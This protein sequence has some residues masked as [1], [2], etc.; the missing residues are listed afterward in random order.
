LEFLQSANSV[1]ADTATNLPFPSLPS[2]PLPRTPS[3]VTYH[4]VRAE[5]TA[6]LEIN[7]WGVQ[8]VARVPS[9]VNKPPYATM[10]GARFIDKLS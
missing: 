5:S 6:A 2:P 1:D 10:F 4:P 9:N 8:P 7:Y 3:T